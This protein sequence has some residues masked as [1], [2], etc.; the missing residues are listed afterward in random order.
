MPFHIAPHRFSHWVSQCLSPSHP[1]LV[2]LDGAMPPAVTS[3][4]PLSQWSMVGLALKRR[5]DVLANGQVYTDSEPVANPG[6]R[7]TSAEGEGSLLALM[8]RLEAQAHLP[9]DEAHWEAFAPATTTLQPRLLGVPPWFVSLSY[10]AA[11]WLEPA[12][13]THWHTLSPNPLEAMAH[14]WPMFRAFLFEEVLLFHHASR[15]LWMH[16]PQAARRAELLASWQAFQAQPL[17]PQP[18]SDASSSAAAA[19]PQA[20]LSPQAFTQ[21]V[22]ALQQGIAAGEFY[23]ANLSLRFELPRL[24]ALSPWGLYHRLAACNPSPFSGVL[25]SPQGWLLSNSPERLV[26]AE[27]GGLLQT[28]PIAGTRGRGA[29]PAEDAALE[30]ALRSCPKERAEHDML[31][32]L[33]RND[34]G[35]V[36]QAGSVQVSEHLSVERYS[37][38]MHLVSNVVGQQVAEASVWQVLAALFPG[39]TITGCPKWRC[40]QALQAVEPVPRGPY[41]GGLGFVE[42]TTGAMDV[43]IL[44]RSL[45]LTP[46][47]PKPW[48][49]L[50]EAQ[51][52]RVRWHAGAGIVSDSV[53]AHE[54][55][56]CL[57]KA[58]AMSQTLLAL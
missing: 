44:I 33:L 36:A 41:T 18:T 25:K 8:H 9:L 15:T 34:L 43:N 55:G 51:P 46:L 29:T 23:Q 26:Q 21:A 6:G 28:R 38:V 11:H 5:V 54:Y 57:K 56:E 48:A 2:L 17:P 10:E 39:G 12:L 58:A 19:T 45:W 27:A 7:L 3:P 52:Y 1:Y 4:T 32:D 20:S 22:Q 35:R 37:H 16:A 50:D 40:M 30:E 31:V 13:H 53:A 47:T 42:P 24:E 14:E 49:T